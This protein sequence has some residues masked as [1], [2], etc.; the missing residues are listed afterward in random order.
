MRGAPIAAALSAAALL[1]GCGGGGGTTRL[2]AD[3]APPI[4]LATFKCGQWQAARADI[5][6]TVIDELHGFYGL[7]VSGQRRTAAY[8]TVLTDSQARSLFDGW[9]SQPFAGNFTLY[10]LYARAAAFGGTAP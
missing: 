8:G 2:A 6:Q 4:P 5:Q 9:C 7:P 3:S 10:K 1:A